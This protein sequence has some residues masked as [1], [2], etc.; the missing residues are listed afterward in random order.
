MRPVVLQRRTCARRTHARTRARASTDRGCAPRTC[1]AAARALQG[2]GMCLA[3]ARGADALQQPAHVPA[4]PSTGAEAAAGAPLERARARGCERGLGG[5]GGE[6]KAVGA[7]RASRGVLVSTQDLSA[8]AAQGWVGVRGAV[9]DVRGFL[10]RHPGGQALLEAHL[11]TDATRAFDAHGHSAA[12]ERMLEKYWVGTLQA[13]GARAG[14]EGASAAGE[15]AGGRALPDTLRAD[16]G[17]RAASQQPQQQEQSRQQQQQL[18]LR[19]RSAAAGAGSDSRSSVVAGTRAPLPS[20][21]SSTSASVGVD[22]R[23]PLVWQVG[24]LGEEYEAWV[25][26]PEDV[27]NPR[28]F[29]SDWAEALTKTS[30]WA[31]PAVWLPF[32][33]ATL[34]AV[35]RQRAG[36]PIAA[37]ALIFTAGAGLL[38]P[39]LEYAVHRFVFHVRRASACSSSAHSRAAGAPIADALAATVPALAN[40]QVRTRSYWGNTL[41]FMIHGCHHKHPMDPLRLVFPP[42]AAAVPVLAL[43]GLALALSRSAPMARAALLTLHAGTVSGY[44]AYDLLHYSLH[45]ATLRGERQRRLQRHH[46]AHHFRHQRQAFSISTTWIDALL[47]TSGKAA[48]SVRG[49]AREAKGVAL[50]RGVQLE[51]AS[52]GRAQVLHA[53][54]WMHPSCN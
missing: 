4:A 16:E 49:G 5:G 26:T 17:G 19:A 35:A 40:I 30:W 37:A 54:D 36:L 42:V 6:N 28:F 32:V 21:S 44:V 33:T 50:A 53:G 20:A 10:P 41:H 25:H 14:A 45:H 46:I 38:W 7:G 34:V 3:S 8:R 22:P 39:L 12:A 9:Y 52:R 51:R 47:G 15:R 48:A 1:D 43:L 13:E 23:R 24:A 18:P 27:P 31:V 11:G 29:R 2:R